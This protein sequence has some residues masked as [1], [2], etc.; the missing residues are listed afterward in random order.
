MQTFPDLYKGFTD[1]FLKTYT[2]VGLRGFYR[3]TG[4]ALIVYV[5]KNSILFMFYGFC[6]Q[7]VRKMAELDQQVELSDLQTA[8]A[9]SFASAFAALALCPT[10][11]VK[12]PLQTVNEMEMSGKIA[13]SHNTIWSV[14]KSILKKD[15]PLGFYHGLSSTLLQEV[16]G[17]FS[18][19]R[20]LT[21]VISALWEV[22]VGGSQGQE[23]ETILANMLLEC[24]ILHN[25]KARDQ[26]KNYTF[27]ELSGHRNIYKK[28][29][30]LF[31]CAIKYFVKKMIN[32]PGMYFRGPRWVD[33]LRS[34][35]REQHGQ[36]DK[37]PSL[38]KILKNCQVWWRAPVVQATREAEAGELI[39]PGRRRLQ[40]SLLLL[41]LECNGVISAHRNL[42]LLGSS[43]STASASRVAGTTG[44]HH[45][46][47][48]NFFLYF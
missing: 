35:V 33:H 48:L 41:R 3:G 25:T 36:H 45:H 46:A 20:W 40:V 32:W 8:A 1:C 26:Y 34:G 24:P 11:L 10:E 29:T 21:P 47:Q 44:V 2:Q 42:R 5:T 16:P 13:K 43:N 18:S 14:L 9:G 38:L 28:E 4:P 15:G 30:N 31:K 6:Q 27:N 7:F 22:E 19:V 37:T 23:T 39:E 12:C 17:H